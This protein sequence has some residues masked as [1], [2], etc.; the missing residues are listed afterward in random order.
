MIKVSPLKYQSWSGPTSSFSSAMKR[1]EVIAAHPCGIG[2]RTDRNHAVG[3]LQTPA[4]ALDQA[5]TAR[6]RIGKS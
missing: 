1:G 3:S 6:R 2:Q 4:C 5:Q